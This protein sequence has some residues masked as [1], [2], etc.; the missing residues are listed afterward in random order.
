MT[1]LE[2]SP[3]P[4]DNCQ[5]CGGLNPVWWVDSD[6][7]NT[8]VNRAEVVCPTCFV[9]AH[10]A[11]TGMRCVWTLVPDGPFRWIED[12]GRSTP[13]LPVQVVTVSA[14]PVPSW[15]VDDTFPQRVADEA[16]RDAGPGSRGHT[17]GHCLACLS[18]YAAVM[19]VLRASASGRSEP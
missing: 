16:H 18:I 5:R 15:T 14:E 13:F 10:E 6:R 3:H 12:E 4:E 17:F 19:S 2:I 9:F 1:D 8:A 7:Y 11:A